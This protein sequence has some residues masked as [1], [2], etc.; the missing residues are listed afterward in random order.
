MSTIQAQ[1]KSRV[2]SW[3][4]EPQRLV[5][6]N[7]TWKQYDALL[8]VFDDRHLRLTYDRGDLEIMTLSC[9]HEG[10][11]SAIG[12]LIMVLAEEFCVEV[13][14]LGSTAFRLKAAERGLEPDQCYYIRSWS[15]IRGKKRLDLRRDPPPDLVVEVDI[16]SSSLDR[17][18]IYASLGVPEV[19]RF[20]GKRLEVYCLSGDVRQYA[21]AARSPTFPQ[22]KLA[23]VQRYLKRSLALDDTTL[24]AGFRS[25]V[26]KQQSK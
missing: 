3:P 22:I 23:G 10:Y 5:L 21:K 1:L 25:W 7:I 11:K 17:M 20:D 12:L 13:K 9:E 15:R 19:W 8:R 6:Q 26:R 2:R 4:N 16:E 14:C 24:L 18:Q